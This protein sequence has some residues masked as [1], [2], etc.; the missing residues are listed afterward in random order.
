MIIQVV[1][2]QWSVDEVA[3]IDL[4]ESLHFSVLSIVY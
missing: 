4:T 3:G 1:V 2:S